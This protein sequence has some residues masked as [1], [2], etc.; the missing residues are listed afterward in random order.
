MNDNNKNSGSESEMRFAKLKW[1]QRLDNILLSI[2]SIVIL[3]ISAILCINL[4][5]QHRNYSTVIS[6]VL[7]SPNKGAFSI[8][9]AFSRALDFAVIKTSSIFLGFLLVLV[10]CLYVLRASRSKYSLSVGE[11]DSTNLALKTTSPGLVLVT[12]GIV[13]INLAIFSKTYIGYDMSEYEYPTTRIENTNT[14]KGKN[15]QSPDVKGGSL[16]VEGN[17]KPIKFKPGEVKLTS[18]QLAILEE[19]IIILKKNPSLK[20]NLEN[21]TSSGV[22]EELSMG[23][24]QKRADYIRQIMASKGIESKRIRIVSYGKSPVRLQKILEDKLDHVYFYIRN[25]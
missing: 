23:L 15:S 16:N 9:L 4:V 2:V 17:L 5:N 1:E 7:Q 18:E 22:S 11:K 24:R 10:G 19:N 13:T 12:L 20:I 14:E 3:F 8:V 6:D 21:E 25:D